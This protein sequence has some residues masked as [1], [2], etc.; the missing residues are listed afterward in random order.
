MRRVTP[1]GDARRA[2]RLQQLEQLLDVD[3]TDGPQMPTEF[4]DW[5]SQVP[6]PRSGP[7]NF[8]LFPFQLELYTEAVDDHEIVVMKSTQVGISAWASRWAMYNSDVHGHT[9]LYVFP[10][11]D[12][13]R[14]FSTARIKPAI[15]AS[16][17][18]RRRQRKTN[19]RNKGLIGLGGGMVYFRGSQERRNLDS[20]DADYVVL[21]EYDMLAQENIPDA[22]RRVS[23]PTSAN[24]I[25]RVG[26]PTVSSWGIAQLYDL[27]DR[28]QWHVQCGACNER[29]TIDFYKNVD[30][31]RMIRVC[32]VCTKPL[33][34]GTGEWVAEF[35]DRGVRGYHVT[36]LIAP[37]AKL[38]PIVA[39]S[40]LRA[41]YERQVFHNKDLGV[42]YAPAEGRLSREA[43]AAAQ[44]AGGGYTLAL[45]YTGPKLTTM[46][47]DVASTRNLNVRISEHIDEFRK[48][49][50]F[51]G[52]VESFNEL[53]RLMTRF[54]IGLCAID[55]LPEGRLAR[56]FAERHP[57]QVY[58]CSYDVTPNPK[59]P[60]VIKV[61]EEMRFCRVRRVEALDAMTEMVRTQKNLL[62]LD[63]P[64]G[65]VEQM[66][67]P[68]R[69]TEKDALGKVTVAYKST[70]PD[71]YAHAEV[72]DIV[73]SEVWGM[74]QGLKD[75]QREVDVPLD[76][77]LDFPRSRLADLGADVVYDPGRTDEP[78]DYRGGY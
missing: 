73:A 47:V 54:Q 12:Q 10:T 32:R 41:P 17:R 4:M 53:D 5:A 64:D 3:G 68:V 62:P 67:A 72:Y 65:Y 7:L 59:T 75:A 56:A 60:E 76:D 42:P 50:L 36:R 19:P 13:V 2:A 1:T 25:R 27:S 70:G 63:L 43:L 28:R 23:G 33:D 8:E 15:D 24:L 69:V 6:E 14:D 74:R 78:Y 45:S 30:Q 22:E 34:V 58:L 51:I 48:R 49:A 38:G 57:G 16:E 52:E 35:P 20:V 39:A 11:Q 44:S 40:K 21:D 26:V 55:H 31:V 18:L 29:Q 46:G 37:T 61:D 9:G 71:D 66:Q 77:L